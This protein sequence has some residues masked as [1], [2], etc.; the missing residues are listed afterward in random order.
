MRI[1][2]DRSVVEVFLNE[3]ASICGRVY[4]GRA[5]SLGVVI[6]GQAAVL[7]ADAWAMRGVWS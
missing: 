6:D 7:E 3:R 2:I 5:D 4:P 1:F